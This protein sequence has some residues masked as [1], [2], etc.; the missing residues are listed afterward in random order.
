MGPF[1]L[2]GLRDGFWGSTGPLCKSSPLRRHFLCGGF[3]KSSLV[4][5]FVKGLWNGVDEIIYQNKRRVE[6]K[7]EEKYT[8]K[9]C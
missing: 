8:Q 9:K 2:D 3:D 1:R 5:V 7:R 6:V 4:F